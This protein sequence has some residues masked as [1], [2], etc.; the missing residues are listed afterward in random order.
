MPRTWIVWF[1]IILVIGLAT[2][3]LTSTPLDRLFT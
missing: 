3:A 1:W 2:A